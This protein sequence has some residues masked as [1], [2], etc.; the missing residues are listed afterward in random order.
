MLRALVQPIDQ[1]LNACL[2]PSHNDFDITVWQIAHE[3]PHTQR[4][5]LVAGSDTEKNAL[6][7]APD[8]ALE[9]GHDG[10][11]QAGLRS[12]FL[13]TFDVLLERSACHRTLLPRHY[14]TLG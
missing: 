5:R 4:L 11:F 3:T 2:R 1:C 6:Y 7:P 13:F 14:F 10:L 9:A 8:P 12:L